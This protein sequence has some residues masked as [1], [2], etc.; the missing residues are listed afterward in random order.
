M[1]IESPGETADHLDKIIKLNINAKA[2][3]SICSVSRL[4]LTECAVL[5]GYCAVNDLLKNIFTRFSMSISLDMSRSLKRF[6]YL[7]AAD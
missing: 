3:I 2:D 7:A 5:K 4:D 6:V 1:H